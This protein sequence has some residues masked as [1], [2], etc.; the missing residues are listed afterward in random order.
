MADVCWD[1]Q[2]LHLASTWGGVHQ[3]HVFWTWIS[4]YSPWHSVKCH[5]LSMC[6]LLACG[7]DISKKLIKDGVDFRIYFHHGLFNTCHAQF[8]WHIETETKWP[9]FCRCQ[10]RQK[11]VGTRQTF[12]TVKPR[13]L[14]RDLTN[15]NRIYKAHQ[16]NE[17]WTM[18]V[19]R[20]HWD[21][22]SIAF[23]WMK[24]IEF[25]IKFH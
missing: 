9:P 25:Q 3:G 5:Y 11:S 1:W 4:N 24:I 19:F 6:Q 2:R 8:I 15:L 13:Y 22:I 17:W 16:T 7:I 10:C 18:K 14:A 21:D 12:R 20:S 23:S